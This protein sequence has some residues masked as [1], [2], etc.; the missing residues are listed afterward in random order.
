V[1]KACEAELPRVLG[2]RSQLT[3]VFMN[4]MIN[5][6]QSMGERGTLTLA[7]RTS[8]GRVEVEIRDTG[9]GIP[10]EHVG[11]VF[12]PFFTTKTGGQGT[13]LG[14]SI[15]YGIVTAHRGT[16]IVDS[17]PGLGTAFTVRLPAA[18]VAVQA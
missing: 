15:A 10:R 12:D 11:Q 8:G 16:I 2:D 4:M 18:A 5:A 13:G 17:E 6:V 1:V 3:Q 9:C 7:T 14:L